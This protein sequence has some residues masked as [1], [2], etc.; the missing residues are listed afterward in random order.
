[1]R[2]RCIRPRIGLAPAVLLGSSEYAAQPFSHGARFALTRRPKVTGR[3]WEIRDG[4]TAAY[5]P[6]LIIILSI[7]ITG[8]VVVNDHCCFFFGKAFGID[9]VE[10]KPTHLALGRTIV[11]RFNKITRVLFC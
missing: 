9:P 2:S 11:D 5:L 1:M 10:V 6:Q 8:D 7:W 3:L 4:R